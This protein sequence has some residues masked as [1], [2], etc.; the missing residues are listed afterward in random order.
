MAQFWHHSL[1]MIRETFHLLQ[2]ETPDF[3]SADL[4]LP[5]IV[6]RPW[7]HLPEPID[8]QIWELMQECVC[9][10]H[11]PIHNTSDLKQR[12]STSLTHGQAYHSTSSTKLLVSGEAVTSC[13]WCKCEGERTSLRTYAK[14]KP[15]HQP[16]RLAF[17]EPPT[18]YQGNTLCFALALGTWRSC[19]NYIH[20][21]QL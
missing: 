13:K 5:N 12:R 19:T 7:Q 1:F 9:T 4:W 18:L 11:A 2:Q 10:R 16:T 14:L 6:L 20:G 21:T 15:S 17:L 8:Y 3:N